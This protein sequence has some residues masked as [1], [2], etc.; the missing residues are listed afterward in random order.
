MIPCGR[1]IVVVR[2]VLVSLG[3]A[4]LFGLCHNSQRIPPNWDQPHAVWQ[5]R[6][7]EH[8]GW[9]PHLPNL[10][11]LP[12][13]TVG[14]RTLATRMAMLRRAAA[15]WSQFGRFSSGGRNAGS[16]VCRR[17]LA[18]GASDRELADFRDNGFFVR[19]C[20]LCTLSA[21]TG[22]PSSSLLSP[23]IV[24]SAH[25]LCIVRRATGDSLRSILSPDE[26]SL[27]QEALEQ[28]KTLVENEIHL[29]YAP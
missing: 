17:G 28:D 27:V 25:R 14:L 19:K 3:Q 4:R 13:N 9:S 22:R 5:T 18:L 6:S 11:R 8:L 21:L 24:R 16:V 2:G 23:A 26:V 10:D 1:R 29:K 15:E 12:T 7:R 20:V